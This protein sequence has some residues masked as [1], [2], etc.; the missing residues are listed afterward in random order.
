MQNWCSEGFSRDR[1]DP[2]ERG[3]ASPQGQRGAPS[4]NIL[5]HSHSGSKSRRIS[6]ADFEDTRRHLQDLLTKGI[7]RESSSPYASPIVLVRKKNNDIRLT[8]DYRLLNSRTV[9]DQYNIPKIE[10]T[11]HSLSG[12]AWFSC[13]D[14][15]SGY[16]QIEM[17]EA[18]KAKTAFWCPLGFYEFNRMPQGICNAPAT[19]QRLM[20]KCM[21]DMA[22]TDVL[23]YLDDLLVFS[24]TLEEHV[25]KL[26][27][28]LTR[29]EEF[30]L[31]LNPDKCQFV[32][33]SVKCLGHVIS[34]GGVQTDPDKIS[35]VTTWPRPRMYE[36]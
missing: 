15:K 4:V 35:A 23:V 34:A 29:L 16:Y 27:K 2:R 1:N 9:R 11:F 32:H 12:A 25:Q 6:P 14:L 20:E 21:G 7:I 26:D 18:D 8:V 22:F 31:R 24:R 28:V 30:G 10:D 33:P 19:F 13:L 36:N 3:R 17:D 5:S